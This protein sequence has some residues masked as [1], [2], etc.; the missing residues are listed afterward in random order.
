MSSPIIVMRGIVKNFGGTCA[1]NQVD[2]EVRPGEV[3]A[4]LGGNGAG[5]STMIKILAGVHNADAGEI[6]VNGKLVDPRTDKLPIAFIHQDLAL[7][8]WMSVAENIALA[9]GYS[10][11]KGLIDWGEVKAKARQALGMMRCALDCDARIVD[12]SQTDKS[13]VAIGRALATEAEV[14]VLDEPTASLPET[15]VIRLF[16][17]LDRLRQSGRGMVYVSHRMDE[18]FRLAN[19]VT[20]MRDGHH[21]ATKRIEDT[22]PPE[23]VALIVGRVLARLDTRPE[24]DRG[25]SLLDCKNLETDEAGPVSLSVYPGEILGFAGL[26]GAG[27]DSIGRAICG[28]HPAKDGAMTLDGDV[29]APRSPAD[30]V[31]RG[32]A[33]VSSKRQEES[34]ALMLAIR[35][36]LF[37]NPSVEGRS[38]FSPMTQAAE[39]K[40]AETR[41]R[42]VGARPSVTEPAIHTFS[43]GNQQKVVLA[44]WLGGALHVLVLEEP[45]MGV[46]VGAKADI[47]ALLSRHTAGG[48]AVIIIS[49]DLEEIAAICDR[50]VIFDRG[51]ISAELHRDQLTVSNLIS[52]VG[53]AVPASLCAEPAAPGNLYNAGIFNA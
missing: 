36:N 47:Y 11:H 53:G 4:L 9:A 20:V 7:V 35:E 31:A 2:F 15:E 8:E 13:I 17:V 5:K 32:I 29:L 21:V 44:R 10:R 1:V 12:L 19:R 42:A 51:V 50:A 26:R 24:I 6:F 39:I 22:S 43:G 48:G 23:L 27:Q 38:A 46:D 14:I 37:I 3:H 45:T 52:Y 28:I 49:S 25:R 40:L 18:I 30:A 41:L 33:F 16:E 34:L